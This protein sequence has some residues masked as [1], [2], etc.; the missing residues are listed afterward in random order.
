MCKFNLFKEIWKTFCK[1]LTHTKRTIDELCDFTLIK[2]KILQVFFLFRNL[3]ISQYFGKFLLGQ[4]LIFTFFFLQP[5]I[6]FHNFLFTTDWRISSYF[7]TI[8]WWNLW[9]FFSHGWMMIFFFFFSLWID[10]QILQFFLTNDWSANF[11]IFPMHWL[12]NV[13]FNCCR[14]EKIFEFFPQLINKFC[15]FLWWSTD[16]LGFLFCD[17]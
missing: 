9:V 17:S 14:L 13:L 5:V 12:E 2:L 7:L 3:W 4:L 16:E 11:V 6:E 10:P 15:D 8:Q 1:I